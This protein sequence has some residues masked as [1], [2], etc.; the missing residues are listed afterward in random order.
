[1]GDSGGSGGSGGLP[2]GRDPAKGGGAAQPVFCHLVQLSVDQAPVHAARDR[3]VGCGAL[4]LADDGRRDSSTTSARS[5]VARATT[6]PSNASA[7]RQND[8]LAPD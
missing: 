6:R 3:P 2:T 4:V 7:N 1:M 8:V 5:V